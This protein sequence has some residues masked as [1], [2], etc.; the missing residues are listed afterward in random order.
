MS[1]NKAPPVSRISVADLSV[2]SAD[3]VESLGPA[4][5]G[6]PYRCTISGTTVIQTSGRR[7]SERKCSRIAFSKSWTVDRTASWRLGFRMGVEIL[8]AQ[9][10]IL[11]RGLGFSRIPQEAYNSGHDE[12]LR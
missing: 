9:N 7:S 3:G 10:G 12:A 5:C 4:T 8:F 2:M 11:L 1:G 6:R